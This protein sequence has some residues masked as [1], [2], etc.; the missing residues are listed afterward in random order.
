MIYKNTRCKKNTLLLV[1]LFSNQRSTVDEKFLLYSVL[2][3]STLFF[4]FEERERILM[5]FQSLYIARK[6]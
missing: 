6:F 2:F 5:S 3:Y 1:L 4:V